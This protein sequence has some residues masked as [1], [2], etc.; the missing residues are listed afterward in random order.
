MKLLK[1]L[2]IISCQ[3]ERGEA[4]DQITQ[5]VKAKLED[6]CDEDS[7]KVFPKAV[8]TV[9]K[10]VLILSKTL[11]PCFVYYILCMLKCSM[12]DPFRS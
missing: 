3:F 9:R 6:D 12:L 7:L 8:D 1:T 11:L 2:W 10:E 4:F 5:T